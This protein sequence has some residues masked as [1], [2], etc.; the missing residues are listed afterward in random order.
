[1]VGSHEAAIKGAVSLAYGRVEKKEGGCIARIYAHSHAQEERV[2]GVQHE[3]CLVEL[4]HYS[5]SVVGVPEAV[6][7]DV[8]GAPVAEALYS[9]YP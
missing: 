2:R 6:C 7:L 1:M 8:A 9:D 5:R 3:R 4:V